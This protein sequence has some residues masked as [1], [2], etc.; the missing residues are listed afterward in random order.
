MLRLVSTIIGALPLVLALIFG[1]QPLFAQQA[2]LPNLYPRMS[3]FYITGETFSETDDSV[4]DECIDPGDHRLLRF[5]IGVANNGSA[6]AYIGSPQ[7]NPRHFVW[8]NTHGHYHVARFNEYRLLNIRGYEVT[9][10]FKQSFCMIDI[11]PLNARSPTLSSGYTC[12]NQGISVGWADLYD[13]SLPCQFVDLKGVRDGVY[14]LEVRT[15]AQRIIAESDF[16]DNLARVRLRF[17][18]D[19]VTQVR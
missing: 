14:I 11:E 7:D 10:G 2:A 19:T 17:D 3:D 1:V 8:S 6:D 12:E 5:T 15:N 18:G 16:N 9:R 4:L 13:S